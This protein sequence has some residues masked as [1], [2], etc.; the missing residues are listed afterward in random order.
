MLKKTINYTD[1][2][3]NEI[4]EDFYFN[5]TEAELLEM[6]TKNGSMQSKL[7]RIIN[8]RDT[9]AIMEIFKEIIVS[10]YGVKSDDGKRFI[11]DE[12]TTKYLTQS[13]AYSELYMSL[14][15]NVDEA[16]AFITGILPAKISKQLDA[17]QL[18]DIKN[19]NLTAIETK[20]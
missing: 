7:K 5:L 8:T 9:S 6:E 18:E 15:G 14:L 11:K 12:E 20:S 10:S 17:Q 3:G 1:F 13:N 16:I 4:S 2:D 19:G